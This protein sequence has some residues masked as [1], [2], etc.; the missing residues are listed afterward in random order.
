MTPKS[1]TPTFDPEK[2]A[3]LTFSDLTLF[4]MS[5]L[6]APGADLD[7]EEIVAAC[8]QMFPQRFSLHK[9]PHWPDS[10]TVARRWSELR[11][12]GYLAKRGF[13]LTARGLSRAK[14]VKKL[15]GTPVRSTSRVSE[16]P[17][18]SAHRYTRAV[19]MSDAF[20][21]FKKQGR[22]ARLNEFD[23]RSMLLCTMETPA[24]TLKRNLEM[25]KEQVQAD[26]R[27]D[28]LAFL[29]FCEA[30]FSHLLVEAPPRILKR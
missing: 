27:K 7:T 1:S 13:R 24:A 25:F 22:K 20:I 10:A 3:A 19:Q 8:F 9:Y 2:Y 30:K 21:Q 16:E 5:H 6:H 12:K 26:N 4:A 11:A 15:I 29:E 28:L 17:K 23:F 18:A 14:R